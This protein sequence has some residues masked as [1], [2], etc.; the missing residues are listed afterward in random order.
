MGM[1]FD[2]KGVDEQINLPFPKFATH[3][4]VELIDV[5]D[6]QKLKEFMGTIDGQFLFSIIHDKFESL[7][8]EVQSDVIRVLSRDEKFFKIP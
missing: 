4:Q 2:L 1:K 7:S 5:E 3:D 8:T 6:L